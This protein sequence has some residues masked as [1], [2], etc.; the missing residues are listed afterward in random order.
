MNT[1]KAKKLGTGNVFLRGVVIFDQHANGAR[2]QFNGNTEYSIGVK[3]MNDDKLSN[4]SL[5]DFIQMMGLNQNDINHIFMKDDEGITF[6]SKSRKAISVL[7]IEN[8]IV[9]IDSLI[10]FKVVVALNVTIWQYGNTT[11]VGV[12]CNGLKVLEKAEAKTIF[13]VF[14]T[15]QSQMYVD[16]VKTQQLNNEVQ[17]QIGDLDEYEDIISD[18]VPF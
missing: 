12:Y 7:D 16:D 5:S 8:Q 10:G 4:K 17:K 2:N 14:S 18:N 6:F 15:S 1:M 11:N 13:D 3:I 9:N